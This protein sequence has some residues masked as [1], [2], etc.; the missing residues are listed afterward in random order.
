VQT[1]G[2]G[3]NM[4]A[5][6]KVRMR[7][8]LAKEGYSVPASFTFSNYDTQDDPIMYLTAKDLEGATEFCNGVD[9]DSHPFIVVKLAN[10]EVVYM[11]GADLDWEDV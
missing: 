9:S 3:V 1:I 6:T 10:G 2:D 8:D 4:S 11:V 5:Y 7:D